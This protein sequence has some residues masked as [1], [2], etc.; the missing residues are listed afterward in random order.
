MP[1]TDTT[2]PGSTRPSRLWRRLKVVVLAAV[3]A[4]LAWGVSLAWKQVGPDVIRRDR[5]LLPAEQVSVSSPPAWLAADVRSEVLHAAQLDRRLSILD[6]NFV[7]VLQDAFALHPWVESVV[8]V[9]KQYPPAVDIEIIYRK[10]VAVVEIAAGGVVQLLPVDRHGIHLPAADVPEIRRRYLPRI[11]GVVGQ[12][13]IGRRWDDPRVDGAVDLAVRLAGDWDRLHLVEILPSAR[14]EINGARR[15]YVY[16]LV[17]RGGTRIVWGAAPLDGP[18]GEPEFHEKQT[19]LERCIQDVGPLDS[20]RAPAVVD[21][22]RHLQVTPRT[23]SL[24]REHA[25]EWQAFAQR[26]V[27]TLRTAARPETPGR[28]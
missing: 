21:V 9:E 27:K 14:P 2:T 12:P 3:V 13:P 19:R 5:Y 18:P 8:R 20:V 4:T 16:D 6:D 28:R 24:W 22:R 15:Y 11:G 1:K 10:P 25:A 17:T 7:Q 23:A 26:L